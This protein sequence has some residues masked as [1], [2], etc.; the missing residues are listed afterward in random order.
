[1]LSEQPLAV[2]PGHAPTRHRQRGGRPALSL[3]LSAEPVPRRRRRSRRQ[4]GPREDDPRTAGA[5]ARWWSGCRP[6]LP[7]CAGRRRR[8]GAR[9]APGRSGRRLRR[10]RG[11]RGAREAK[12]SRQGRLAGPGVR[13]RRRTGCSRGSGPPWCAPG[14]STGGLVR[15]RRRGSREGRTAERVRSRAA[16]SASGG[17]DV[18][19]VSSPPERAHLREVSAGQRRCLYSSP[20]RLRAEDADDVRVSFRPGS[21]SSR[22]WTRTSSGHLRLASARDSATR[23]RQRSCRTS[24]IGLGR[25]RVAGRRRHARRRPPPSGLGT[26]G[27]ARRWTA[28]EGPSP[29]NVGQTADRTRP[30]REP[31]RLAASGSA[32]SRAGARRRSGTQR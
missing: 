5:R 24:P 7:R 28:L 30:G 20:M 9:R 8:H 13:R 3:G 12:P 17:E 6:G 11:S 18:L 29:T 2:G 31:G 27:A 22:S 14:S 1:M 19:S 15:Q 21:T 4:A 23:S 16:P 32:A 26:E 10:W 25:P